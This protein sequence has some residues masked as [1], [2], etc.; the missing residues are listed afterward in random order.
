M[1]RHIG[2]KGTGLF[3]EDYRVRLMSYIMRYNDLSLFNTFIKGNF[4]PC[5]VGRSCHRSHIMESTCLQVI[6]L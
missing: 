4:G 3:V 1:E 6:V 5:H 2:S